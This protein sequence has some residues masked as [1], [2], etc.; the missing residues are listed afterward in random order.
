M[1]VGR[2]GGSPCF[3]FYGSLDK[4]YP[5]MFMF[6][7]WLQ[8]LLHTH[9]RTHARTHA[10]THTH[11]CTNILFDFVFSRIKWVFIV[12]KYR[13]KLGFLTVLT[14]YCWLC[15]LGDALCIYMYIRV[16]WRQSLWA[17]IV[18]LFLIHCESISSSLR[19]WHVTTICN[20]CY[21]TISLSR[22]H[23]T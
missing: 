13:L 5:L 8:K 15:S 21:R 14:W 23:L 6:L 11:R 9:T 12:E 4:L 20:H 1:R 22:F 10:R 2:R 17:P 7:L 3:P 16:C 18:C 19:W